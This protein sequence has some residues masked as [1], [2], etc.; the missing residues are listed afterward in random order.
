MPEKVIN[1]VMNNSNVGNLQYEIFRGNHVIKHIVSIDA[2]MK[3]NQLP[4]AKTSNTKGQSK[5]KVGNENI[6]LN[7]RLFNQTYELTQ[8]HGGDM[9]NVFT[10]KQKHLVITNS[11]AN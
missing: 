7:I 2:A 6:K 3:K 1:T 5:S 11:F 9:D 8:I 4:L 10:P